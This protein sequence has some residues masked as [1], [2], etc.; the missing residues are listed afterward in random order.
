MLVLIL[1]TPYT[2]YLSV[3]YSP[4]P[5]AAATGECRSIVATVRTTV[6]VLVVVVV[7]AYYVLVYRL[8]KKCRV[9]N[10]PPTSTSNN[11]QE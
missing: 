9:S 7:A 3:A 4:A 8:F 1:Y 6:V 2:L 10:A 11:L 5:P